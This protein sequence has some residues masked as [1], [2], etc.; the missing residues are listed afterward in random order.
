MCY[1]DKVADIINRV[2]E[3]LANTQINCKFEDIIEELKEE[4]KGME[5]ETQM[6]VMEVSCA[7]SC[8]ERKMP[9]N[10]I[11]RK[12]RILEKKMSEERAKNRDLKKQKFTTQMF[13]SVKLD[14]SDGTK[15][16]L[17]E[18]NDTLSN[19]VKFGLDDDTKKIFG[20]IRD[21]V[22]SI[23]AKIDYS[24]FS[25]ILSNFHYLLDFIVVLVIANYLRADLS[26]STKSILTTVLITYFGVKYCRFDTPWKTQMME[27]EVQSISEF[28]VMALHAFLISNAPTSF[29]SAAKL[30]D[31]LSNFG[32]ISENAGKGFMAVLSIVETFINWFRMRLMD[33]DPVTLVES[34]DEDLATWMKKA[35]FVV[36]RFNGGDR[37]VNIDRCLEIK[38]LE[39]EAYELN[40]KYGNMRNK[41][42]LFGKFTCLFTYIKAIVAFYSDLN[43]QNHSTKVQ[44][45]AACFISVPGTGK[46]FPTQL[47]AYS[48]LSYVLPESELESFKKNPYI[49]IYALNVDLNFRDG[50]TGSEKVYIDSEWRQARVVPGVYMPNSDFIATND[51]H[52]KVAN[53]AEAHK[54]GKV[55]EEPWFYLACTNNFNPEDNMDDITSLIRYSMSFRGLTVG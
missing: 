26:V 19:G 1:E 15:N 21:G 29:S 2:S 52:P 41:S 22:A 5:F 49:Y 45:V 18:L 55:R 27:T 7:K 33:L 50:M 32:K 11:K 4:I 38:N 9:E 17:D 36:N 43:F 3:D 34:K 23:N 42:A 53:M 28:A 31:F 48:L 25:G 37:V 40:S 54:K 44:T 10:E 47:I 24:N 8:K 16:L 51:T 20:S 13:P 46:T 12:L 39:R 14:L 35:E 30:G 6:K